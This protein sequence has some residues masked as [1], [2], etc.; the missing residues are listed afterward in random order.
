MTY[1]NQ[2]FVR[3]QHKQSDSNVFYSLMN[4]KTWYKDYF[5]CIMSN[6]QIPNSDIPVQA[7]PNCIRKQTYAWLLNSKKG[8]VE[9]VSPDEITAHVFER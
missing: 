9:R 5:Q 8:L 2:W 6:E 4:K 1:A 7:S 3:Y